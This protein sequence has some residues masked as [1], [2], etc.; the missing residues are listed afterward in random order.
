MAERHCHGWRDCAGKPA[1]DLCFECVTWWDGYEAGGRD[2]QLTPRPKPA[3]ND[4]ARTGAGFQD[5]TDTLWPDTD[6][7]GSP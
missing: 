5:S 3:P 4:G 7:S 2:A 6:G 1:N